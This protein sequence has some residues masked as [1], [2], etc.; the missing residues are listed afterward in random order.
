MEN[1]V[2]KQLINKE[3][4]KTKEVIEIYKEETKPV[5]PDCAVD[6]LSRNDAMNNMSRVNSL[7]EQA[8][9]KLNALEFVLT[10]VDTPEF[11]KCVHCRK[12]IPIGRILVRPESLYCIECSQ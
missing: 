11:G 10:K 6:I 4:D 1:T 7:L 12:E 9:Q 8:K 3:I 2:I 5:A